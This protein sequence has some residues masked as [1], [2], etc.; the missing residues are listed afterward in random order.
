MK[1]LLALLIL[2]MTIVP[3]SIKEEKVESRIEPEISFQEFYKTVISPEPAPIQDQTVV[4]ITVTRFYPS[5][6]T[7]SDT[8]MATMCTSKLQVN[9][10]GW[11]TYQGKIVVGAATYACQARCKNRDKYGPL[12]EGFRIYNF[13]DEVKLIIEGVEYTGIVLDSCGACMYH[14]NGEELQRYDIFTVSGKASSSLLSNKN[15][16][17]IKA[18]LV[19][20]NP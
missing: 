16:G 12:P 10:K 2:S 13:Y 20:S 19:I 15:A 14:V 1:T 11:Y 7:G 17:K 3:I 5:D 9:D 4:D 6:S 18:Q 8:C